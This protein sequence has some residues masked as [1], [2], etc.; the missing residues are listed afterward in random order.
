MYVASRMQNMLQIRQHIV[1]KVLKKFVWGS[2]LWEP[3]RWGHVSSRSVTRSSGS[4]RPR[5]VSALRTRIPWQGTSIAVEVNVAAHGSPSTTCRGTP[6]G[7]GC[8]RRTTQTSQ[9]STLR[10][11]QRKASTGRTLLAWTRHSASR[12]EEPKTER[13]RLYRERAQAARRSI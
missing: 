5:S 3:A 2:R 6:I 10:Q 11:R 1:L 7:S 8:P 13:V 12:I 9:S 4:K